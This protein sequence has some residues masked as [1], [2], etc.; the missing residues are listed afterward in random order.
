MAGLAA[1]DI[2]FP[3]RRACCAFMSHGHEVFAHFIELFRIAAEASQ[4][5]S[6]S[7]QQ[8]KARHA[9]GKMTIKIEQVSGAPASVK[10]SKCKFYFGGIRC[11]QQESSGVLQIGFACRRFR[12]GLNDL[13][14]RRC[15]TVGC[16]SSAF[17]A[18]IVPLS[19]RILTAL[20]YLGDGRLAVVT[21]CPGEPEGSIDKRRHGKISLDS[22]CFAYVDMEADITLRGGWYTFR[23]IPHPESAR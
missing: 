2:G 11:S 12:A 22:R 5:D 1:L 6:A 21:S 13:R 14:C 8:M 20:S 9:A 18:L 3:L 10:L 17:I 4:A 16:H 23:S 7:R 19:Q 15:V